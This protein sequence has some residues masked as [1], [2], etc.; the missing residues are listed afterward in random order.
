[1]PR[2]ISDL[3]FRLR[4]L[5]FRREADR[6]LHDE[7]AFHL[8]MDAS[9]LRAEGYSAAEADRVA[10][11]R[12]GSAA[13][14][15]EQ[16]RS[17]WGIDLLTQLAEDSRR[18]LRQMRRQPAFSAIAITALGLGIGASVALTSVVNS[19][20]LRPLPYEHEAQ[21]RVFSGDY[22]WTAE[23]Y[24][25]LRERSGVFDLF[26]PFSTDGLTYA[27]RPNTG[28]PASI[29]QVAVSSP[30]LFDALGARPLIGR[31][32]DARD[33]RPDAAPVVVLSYGLWQ[34]DFASDP[35]VIGRQILLGGAP[36][37][38]IGVMPRGFYFPAPLLRAWAPLRIDRAGPQYKDAFLT[39]VVRTRGGMTDVQV[40]A[41]MTR[42]G[43]LLGTR[44]TYPPAWDHTRNLS[45]VPVH[46]YVLGP[47]REPLFLLLGA[48]GLLLLIACANAAALVLVRTTDRSTEMGVRRALGASAGRLARQVL[49]ESLVL[50]L[51]SAVAGAILAALGFRLLVARL[52]LGNGLDAVAT[53]GG[54]AFGVA[55]VL[56]L[57]IALGVAIVPVR[58]VLHASEMGVNRERSERGLHRGTRAVHGVIIASQVAFAVLLVV[59]ATL[60]IRSV[61]RIRDIDLGFDARNATAFNVQTE[62][63][64]PPE[65]RARL[66]VD[67]ASRIRA[68]PGVTAAGI[69]NRIPVRDLGYQSRVRIE[70][71]PDLGG[72]KAPTSFYRT[73][74]AGFFKTMGMQIVAG[75]PIDSTD[76]EGSTPVAVVNET[77][78]A[79]M[80]PGQNPLGKHLIEAWSGT[81]VSRL[82]VGV[83]RDARLLRPTMKIPS[84][85]WVPFTQAGS[86]QNA[87]VFVV[88]STAPA[89]SVIASV[90]KAVGD[91]DSRFAIGGTQTMEDALDAALAA[92][93]ELRFFF[94]V[95][96]AL[97][98]S[99]GAIGVFGLVSY[100]V[101][102]RRAE[103]AVRMSLGASPARV[104]REVLRLG[105]GP[106]II[107]VAAGS[108]LA[109]AAARLISGFLYGI[110]ASDVASFVAAG[111]TLLGAGIV[112][113]LL[114]A[115][116]ASRTSPAEALRAE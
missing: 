23:E 108:A 65:I 81:P 63:G 95:F 59:G 74:S 58:R 33:D 10:K 29:L 3:L 1:M 110:G 98:L 42:L 100:A 24:D 27:P 71:R 84:A 19:L 55:F 16:A 93:L 85:F 28:E 37:T 13:Y 5:V 114:P 77:F 20:V 67:L 17:G 39:M 91:A 113:A 82:V 75:R 62:D 22:S 14:E 6:D 38:V 83:T 104:G 76:V 31:T 68:L 4:T 102:R 32:Y 2:F 90:R 46:A 7:L 96:A 112:A 64:I 86:G 8:S 26:A 57:F 50:A 88:R 35:G 52:P 18:A 89:A 94:T 54:T 53:M 78:A 111:L 105:V 61:Q 79:A 9:R 103:F 97:A 15:A 80:W 48:V 45:A 36:T 106:V 56:A 60:L 115:V 73:A 109:I 40:T 66:Y 72:N 47:V 107:G 41:E 49:A 43:K 34:Q 101:A 69:T 92:P 30:S 21:A 116:R 70:G 87:T 51:F 12:F 44:F 99:L 11:Q 25:F